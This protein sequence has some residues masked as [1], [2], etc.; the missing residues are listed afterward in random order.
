MPS[1][2]RKPV[3][4]IGPAS[5]L[6]ELSISAYCELSC[7]HSLM[8]STK[9]VFAESLL[10]SFLPSARIELAVSICYVVNHLGNLPNG[11]RADAFDNHMVVALLHTDLA[12]GMNQCVQDLMHWRNLNNATIYPSVR[13]SDKHD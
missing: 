9:S 13:T 3:A 11:R 12:H 4:V 8:P 10:L 6:T 7:L 2:L 1:A 5:F